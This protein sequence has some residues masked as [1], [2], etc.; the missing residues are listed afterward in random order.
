MEAEDRAR[1]EQA[2]ALAA[3]HF[4]RKVAR[5]ER[6]I[7]MKQA[8]GEETEFLERRLSQVQLE[9]A[10]AEADGELQE[11]IV[12]AERLRRIE[13]ENEARERYHQAELE[14][15]EQERA[16]REALE[17]TI[18]AGVRTTVQG[19]AQSTEAAMAATSNK[20]AAFAAEV[21]EFAGSRAKILAIDAATHFALAAA[22]AIALNPVKAAAELAAGAKSSAAAAAMGALAAATG[23]AGGAG[24]GGPTGGSSFS[25]GPPNTGTRPGQANSA[26]VSPLEQNG[27]PVPQSGAA[28]GQVINLNVAGSFIDSGGQLQEMINDAGANGGR[29]LRGGL[30]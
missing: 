27:Q 13:Q 14:R 7:E 1:Q 17:R 20:G 5:M 25:Q 16:E 30:G 28:G 24:A 22:Y 12:H 8:L 6:E 21:S 2:D 19:L 15:L 18:E 10:T 29:K 9:R 11:Q 3:E 23:A 26:P 4:A